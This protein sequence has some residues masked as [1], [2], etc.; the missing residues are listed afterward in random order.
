MAQS[1]SATVKAV[2]STRKFTLN[3]AA[4]TLTSSAVKK[5]KELLAQNGDAVALRVGVRT[6]GCSG[7]A[8][9]LDYATQK[10]KLDEQV[11]QDG[12]KVLI[13]AKAQLTLLGTQ[14]DFVED[15]LSS[16]FVFHN[17]NVKGTCGCGES[18]HV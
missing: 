10:Q 4:I 2:K 15:D 12:V 18:F 3:R 13:D 17:P 6:R 14:M 11:E 9:T 5:V 16:G 8:Y 1:I 7:L